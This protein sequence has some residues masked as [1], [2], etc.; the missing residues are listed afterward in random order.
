MATEGYAEVE[1]W[2]ARQS[3]YPVIYVN[4]DGTWR[5]CTASERKHLEEKYHPADG[6]RPYVK[7]RYGLRTPDGRLSGFLRRREL[8]INARKA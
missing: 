2:E 7:D 8:P 5:E 3:P 6:A 4:D 1:P